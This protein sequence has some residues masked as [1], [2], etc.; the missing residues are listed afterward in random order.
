MSKSEIAP[1]S[2]FQ[3]T[4][5]NTRVD[6]YNRLSDRILRSLGYPFINVELHR[7]QIYENISIA[8]EYFS[9][10]AGYTKE[11]LMF[12]SALYKKDHGINLADLFTLQ[13]TDT[14]KEQKDLKTFNK[15]FTK[16][17]DESDTSFVATS[18]IKAIYFDPAYLLG[19]FIPHYMYDNT[20]LSYYS[21]TYEEHRAQ[22]V[23]GYTHL[24][25]LS[26]V[27]TDTVS[28]YNNGV[29]SSY[30]AGIEH[31]TNTFLGGLTG[32]NKV[33][34]VSTNE[35]SYFAAFG[36]STLEQLNFWNPTPHSSYLITGKIYVSKYNNYVN[37]LVVKNLNKDSG[38]NISAYILP[39]KGQWADIRFVTYANGFSGVSD[40]DD[41]S[42]FNFTFTDGNTTNIPTEG[43]L[44]DFVA[45]KDIQ[46]KQI[47]G[48]F[49]S[50]DITYE[51][52]EGGG[53]GNPYIP[54]QDDESGEDDSGGGSGPYSDSG[55]G[56]Y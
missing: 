56:G 51:Q 36:T 13:N 27:Y 37:G 33:T 6:N 22:S 41:N 20:G 15:D 16:L 10:F 52:S 50:G 48:K 54:P 11:Y 29:Y 40:D 31:G 35:N 1:I 3:S 24:S 45:F 42:Y 7:D 46:V 43:N 12:D 17:I 25:M 9:K 44:N 2:G 8:I 53:S 49:V 28:T 30:G 23:L 38:N 19:N 14:F 34:P 47:N 4:N 26:T 5:L 55:G 21:G 18:A 39:P 32:Y